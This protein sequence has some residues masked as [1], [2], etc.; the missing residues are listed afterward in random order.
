MSCHELKDG[1]VCLFDI[2]FL[3]PHCNKKYEDFNDKYSNR[4]NN[5]KK[6]FTTVKCE[7]GN[8]F[9]LTYDITGKFQSYKLGEN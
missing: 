7:C 5:N 4:I 1:F 9:G 3:C 8:K 2:D 6:C